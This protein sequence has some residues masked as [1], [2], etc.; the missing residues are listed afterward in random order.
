MKS[1]TYPIGRCCKPHGLNG[2]IKV[3]S[4][5]DPGSKILEYAPWYL[6]NGEIVTVTES[7]SYAKGFLVK[8]KDYD[9]LESISK[10]RN[11]LIC[12][13]LPKLKEGYYWKDLEGLEVF[14]YCNN[15]IGI[16]EG[17]TTSH[18]TDLLIIKNNKK[19][20]YAPFSTA[21]EVNIVSK[22]I[23]IDWHA[24]NFND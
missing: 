12:A 15:H 8:L 24:D 21:T 9:S 2:E 6:E 3:E 11:I 1:D 16:V 20:M 22:K 14:D 23:T 18:Q 4:F 13:K 17:L 7:R 19:I 10:I 5:T